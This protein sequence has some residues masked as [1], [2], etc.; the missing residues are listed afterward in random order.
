MR[1]ERDMSALVEWRAAHRLRRLAA[2]TDSHQHFSFGSALPYRVVI[3]IGEP[4]AV[5]GAD[6]NAVSAGK[7]GL[8][9]P[10][11][12]KFAAAIEHYDWSFT[13]VEHVDIA[14]RIDRD[15]GNIVHPSIGH[16]APF[17]DHFIEI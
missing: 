2:D 14:F 5:I 16:L 9:A 11:M 6:G 10:A 12:Q 15:A 4:H 13:A 8:I 1:V 7:H 3:D 17:F